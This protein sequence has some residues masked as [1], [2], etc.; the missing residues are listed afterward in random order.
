MSK[1]L[2]NLLNE[3]DLLENEAVYFYEDTMWN[4]SVSSETR[5]K[6]GKIHPSAIYIFNGA[7]YILFFDLTDNTDKELEQTIHKQVWSFDQAP[8]AFVIKGSEI[9][10]YNAFAYEK[11]VKASGLQE[12]VLED[13]VQR[14][15]VFSFWK[16]QSGETWKWLQNYYKEKKQND[17][18]KRV[19]QKLFDNIKQVR[20]WLNASDNNSED[21]SNTLILRLIFIRYLIDRNVEMNLKFI[22][23][24]TIV[25]R[26]NSF[27]VLIKDTNALNE[28][29]FE[30]NTTFNGVLFKEEIALFQ[31]QSEYLSWVF[32][33]KDDPNKNTLFDGTEFYFNIFDFDIIPVEMISGI[34]ESLLDPETKNADSAFYTPLF[35]VE[36][37]LTNTI[38]RYFER[39]ENQNR[40]EC[41]VFDASMGSGIFLVQAFRR[42]VD[43]E[44]KITKKNN[45]SKKRL[46]E[47]ATNNLWGTDINLSAI[48]VACFSVYI[49]ILDYEDPRTIMDQFHFKS[50]NF[51]QADFFETNEE[52]ILNSQ[53]KQVPFDF[54]LGNPPWKKD[55]SEKHLEWVNARKIY[56]KKV[57]G[58]IEIAQDF[59]LR[60]I[61]FMKDN[62]ECSLIVSS[63]I[64]YNISSTSRVF[65]NKFLTSTNV[66]SILD[67]SPVRRYIFEGKKTEINQKTGHNETKSLGGPALIITFKKTDGNFRES[68]I[69]HTSV[70]SNLFTKYYK[71]LVIEKFDRKQISQ[72]HFIDNEWMFKVALYGNT[73]DYRLLK[74]LEQ[75]KTKIINLIDGRKLTKGAGILK[76]NANDYKPY[77][78]IIDGKILE[79][80]DVATFYTYK[81]NPETITE[82]ESCIKSG[83]VDNLYKGYQIL[84]K[85]QAKEESE[86]VIS[87]SKDYVFRKGI[88][89]ITSQDSAF[90]YELYGYLIS[91]LYTYFIYSVS[92]AWGVATRPAIRQD[93]EYLSFPIVESN[94]KNELLKL[95][96]EF[97]ESFRV[98]YAQELLIGEVFINEIAKEKINEIINQTY[99]ING[100]EKD[101]ID[102]VLNVS[103]FQ[104]QESKINRIVKKVSNNEDILAAY[105]DVFFSEL[106]SI[107]PNEYMSV[108]IY[109]L[110]HFIALN[111]VFS[112]EKPIKNIDYKSKEKDEWTILK[113]IAQTASMSK[114]SK[115]IFIQKDIKGFETDSF[116]IIKPNEYKCWHRAMAWYDVAEIKQLIEADELEYL[117]ENPDAI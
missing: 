88:F 14:K 13:G 64:F 103:R 37:I 84:I 5:K 80:K 96:D 40:S 69:D 87:Y 105:S 114:L 116:Y 54:I 110:D 3:L 98:H 99:Q 61:E 1:E 78:S 24:E 60:A 15:D 21:N 23:G 109:N 19:H 27:S 8:L 57:K 101:L 111:F 70:K 113:K 104:F 93:E 115:D 63:P 71:A 56:G 82:E 86:L 62:T 65:K 51:H 30:L 106:K 12:I 39:K 45:I 75:N 34:Y 76:G 2:Q 25:A 31:D 7:P 97:L 26:R 108:E 55:K 79:N 28:F 67:L 43:R 22:P 33:E 42:M 47:I 35:I 10:I 58:E 46:S 18:I 59:L 17:R 81:A 6:L 74:K 83:R 92:C 90:V 85:E 72:S 77:P 102:Y 89:G 100:Y 112:N 53:I 44:L 50:L 29:F 11:L 52:H 41:K 20:E 48:K 95:V 66:V 16:L 107:Y 68:I 117:K 49:A 36:H 32:S 9:K 4:S 91:D 73:L 38:D 94:Q